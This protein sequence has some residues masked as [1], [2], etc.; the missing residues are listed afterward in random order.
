MRF[1]KTVFAV[2]LANTAGV[3]MAADSYDTSTSVLTI[4]QVKVGAT[5]YKNVTVLLGTVVSAGSTTEVAADTYDTYDTSTSRL[6]IPVVTVGS[7]TYYGVTVTLGN[8]LTVGSSCTIASTCTKTGTP[9]IKGVLPGDSRISVMFNF[10]GGKITAA[11]G[12]STTYVQPT[13]F[14]ALC[15][16][17]D[18]GVT[19]ISTQSSEYAASLANLTNPLVVSGL[20][21]GKTYTCTVT[22]SA[23]GAIAATSSSSS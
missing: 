6:S 23:S 4:A 18:G 20:T 17:S 22:A 19:G 7:T 13:S 3:L 10:M 9:E 1:W 11:L 2:V 8:V 14:S 12:S 5:L 15:K 16:S 21:N